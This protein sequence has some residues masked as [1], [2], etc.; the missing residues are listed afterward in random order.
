MF[1]C[2]LNSIRF[3]YSRRGFSLALF[4][5]KVG[6]TRD[7]FAVCMVCILFLCEIFFYV[8]STRFRS[9]FCSRRVL[10][11][12]FHLAEIKRTSF[13]LRFIVLN[14]VKL[15]LFYRTI[16]LVSRK[17]QL[18]VDILL[19]QLGKHNICCRFSVRFS[20]VNYE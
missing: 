12:I 11:F 10:C 13:C 1:Y 3:L 2:D 16:F 19:Y 15:I 14:K 7:K 9:L 20:D 18:R 5:N 17:M 4:C 6:G 8:S